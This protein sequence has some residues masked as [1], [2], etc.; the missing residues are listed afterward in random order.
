MATPHLTVLA[1]RRIDPGLAGYLVDAIRR[2]IDGWNDR[3]EPFTWT[4]DADTILAK[5]KRQTTSKHATC[6]CTLA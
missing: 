3:C 5:A 1:P 4:K 6:G 2:Y